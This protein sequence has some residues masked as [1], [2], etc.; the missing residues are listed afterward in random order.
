MP[1]ARRARDD[2]PR[3][4]H[5][6]RQNLERLRPEWHTLTLKSHLGGLGIELEGSKTL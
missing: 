2:R 6:Q 1:V 5:E 3:M 4:T